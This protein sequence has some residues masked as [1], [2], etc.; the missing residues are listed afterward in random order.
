MS[1]SQS[2]TIGWLALTLLVMR[3]GLRAWGLGE[4]QRVVLRPERG[5]LTLAKDCQSAALYFDGND[6]PGVARS[7]GSLASDLAEVWT[8]LG[9]LAAGQHKVNAG[10]TGGMP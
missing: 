6:Y 5:A 8:P 7:L 1:S 3:G 9:N 10:T 4:K 2:R